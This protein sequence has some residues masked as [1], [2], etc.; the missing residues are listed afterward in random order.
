MLGLKV[1]GIL[2]FITNRSSKSQCKYIRY[3]PHYVVE[4]NYTISK[5]DSK[6]TFKTETIEKIKNVHELIIWY[7]NQYLSLR[8]LSTLF[9]VLFLFYHSVVIFFVFFLTF[10]FLQNLLLFVQF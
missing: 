5:I 1:I 9:F 7:I 10:I 2:K 3:L 6:K 8:S 4:I